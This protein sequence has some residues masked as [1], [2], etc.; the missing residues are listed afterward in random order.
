MKISLVGIFVVGMLFYSSPLAFALTENELATTAASDLTP[1]IARL[2]L[3]TV[4]FYK[5]TNNDNINLDAIKFQDKLE[6]ELLKSGIC[7]VVDRTVLQRLYAEMK[8]SA[9]DSQ[10]PNTIKQIG[11]LYGVGGFIYADT[12]NDFTAGKMK[13]QV[14]IVRLVNTETGELFFCR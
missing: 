6:I 2:P 3:K 1:A 9:Q 11:K 13:N 14:L 4:A 5:L 7:D 10:N 8:L 12:Y